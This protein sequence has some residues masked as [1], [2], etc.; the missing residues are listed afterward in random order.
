MSILSIIYYFLIV[1]YNVPFVPWLDDRWELQ[2]LPAFFYILP[3]FIFLYKS[4][5][6][7]YRLC[8]RLVKF[9]ERLGQYSYEI[10]LLQMFLLAFLNNKNVGLVSYGLI[11]RFAW[12]FLILSLS[13]VPVFIYKKF[14]KQ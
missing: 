7:V 8:V 1:K 6:H 11:G 10:F 13:I 14:V 4:Y 12:V 2:Q 9:V 3:L 5:S